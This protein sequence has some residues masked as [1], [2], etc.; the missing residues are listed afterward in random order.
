MKRFPSIPA[1]ISL[2]V[3]IIFCSCTKQGSSLRFYTPGIGPDWYNQDISNLPISD[4]ADSLARIAVYLSQRY[5]CDGQKYYAYRLA[6]KAFELNGEDRYIALSLSHTAYLLADIEQD[7]DRMVE[8]AEIGLNA[9]EKAGKGKNDPEANYYY[10]LHLG[11]ILQTKGL[12]ALGKL[13]RLQEALKISME[14]PGQDSGGPLRVLGMLYLSA[15]AWPQG[16]GDIEKA[17][18][19][20]SEASTRYPAHPQNHIFYAKALIEDDDYENAAAALQKAEKMAIEEIWGSYYMKKWADEIK[21]LQ[22]KIPQ[23]KDE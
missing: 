17:L 22:K 18:E 5:A 12:F 6:R 7:E 10:A 16:I 14:K 15:P 21:Q 1:A 3:L 8:F 11:L 9:A 19:L 2:A 20:L 4:D 23:K 13:P